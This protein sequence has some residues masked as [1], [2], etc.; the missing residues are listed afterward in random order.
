MTAS[1]DGTVRVWDRNGKPLPVLAGHTK[2]VEN[3]S[4]SPD[5]YHIITASLDGTV[6]GWIH[7]G[8]QVAVLE[9]HE[10]VLDAKFSPDGSRI[11]T[12]GDS[13]DHAAR[14]WDSEWKQIAVLGGHT[15][16]VRSAAFSPDRSRIVTASLDHTARLWDSDGNPLAVLV[17][18]TAQVR[19]AAFSRDGSCI[20]TASDDRTARLW[21][22]DGKPLAVFAGHDGR[23]T[24]AAFSRDGSRIIT[25]AED[26]TA[27]LYRVPATTDN[28]STASSAADA[29]VRLRFEHSVR[30]IFEDSRG[31]YWFGTGDAGVCRFDGERYTYFTVEDSLASNQVRTIFEDRNGVIWFECG[32]GISSYD[33]ERIITHTS[34]DYTSKDAWRLG[35]EDL[36]FKGD[37]AYGIN[38]F[39]GEP[40]VYRYDGETFTWLTFPLPEDRDRPN[41]S[42]SVTGM[43]KGE[44]GRL[45]FAT[46]DAVI[47]YDGESFTIIDDESLGLTADSGFLHIRCVF[48]D[49]RGRV[50]IGNNG[51]GVLLLEGDTITN[52]TQANGVGRR[53]HRSGG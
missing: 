52:F 22:K 38:G 37:E 36:W 2:S 16:F 31:H 3:A 44:G 49:S 47:G 15:S 35:A 41:V 17:G 14:L 48:E 12:V 33:G 20:V 19:H 6:R 45:W 23:L 43:S 27:R 34:R 32:Y 7:D 11:V 39:E 53:D 26:G 4:I 46:Y 13:A 9:G 25:A 30:A 5:G 50:W 29:P 18:H 40:G 10:G 28:S 24:H 8:T 51:I 21:D 1:H 42:Y